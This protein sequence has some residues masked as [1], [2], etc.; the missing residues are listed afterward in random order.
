MNFVLNYPFNWFLKYIY[1]N[2]IKILDCIELN[3]LRQV[4][5]KQDLPDEKFIE[6]M[7]NLN[8]LVLNIY[9]S[10]HCTENLRNK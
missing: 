5:E 1:Y 10:P 2:C 8:Q 6:N 3:P 4:K 9:L 7:K